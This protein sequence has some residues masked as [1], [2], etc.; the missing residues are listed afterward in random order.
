[1]DLQREIQVDDSVSAAYPDFQLLCVGVED[2][3]NGPS[4]DGSI[5]MLR[6]AEEKARELF[7]NQPVT[8][9]PH[10]IAWRN[11]YGSFGAKPSKYHSSVESLLRRVVRGDSI[12]TINR[13]VDAYNAVSLSYILPVGGEDPAKGS[14]PLRLFVANGDEEFDLPDGSIEAP[15]PGEVVWG[16]SVGVTCRRWNWRQG[17]RTRIAENTTT[18]VFVLEA[19]APYSIADLEAAGALLQTLL[20]SISPGAALTSRVIPAGSVGHRGE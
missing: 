18:A 13:A 20:T 5:A 4:D 11:V 17:A 3:E 8:S 19:M 12:P 2:F 1:M 6:S 7:A 10:V 14:G 9:H 16:D 15:E